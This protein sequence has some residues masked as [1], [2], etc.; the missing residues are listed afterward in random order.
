VDESSAGFTRLVYESGSAEVSGW[1]L[2]RAGAG[3]EE[4]EGRDPGHAGGGGD[5]E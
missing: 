4:E 5:Q 1:G 3:P 2:I